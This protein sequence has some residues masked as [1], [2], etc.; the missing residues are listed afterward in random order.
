T[1]IPGENSCSYEGESNVYAVYYET[2]TAYSEYVFKQQE[3]LSTGQFSVIARVKKLGTGVPSSIG[4]HI[5]EGGTAKGFSQ[6]STG[7]ILENE[8]IL[9]I[10]LQSKI[11]GCQDEA[12][13]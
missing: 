10:S 12:I 2:G 3:D 5:T 1:Y 4:G 8:N 9:P 13:E 7:S 11:L 6:Q